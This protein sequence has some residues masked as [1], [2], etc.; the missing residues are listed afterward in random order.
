MFSYKKYVFGGPK[1]PGKLPRTRGSKKNQKKKFEKKTN[2]PRLIC[3]CYVESKF[4][5][6]RAFKPI[7]RGCYT[8]NPI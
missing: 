7:N 4:G 5:A 8:L 3:S 1:M 6:I 2:S